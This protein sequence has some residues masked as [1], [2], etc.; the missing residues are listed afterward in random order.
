[1]AKK[2]TKERD[3]VGDYNVACRAIWDKFLIKQ[4]Y[5]ESDGKVFDYE[6]MHSNGVYSY[7]VVGDDY[8][9]IEDAI[10]DLE[11]DTTVGVFFDWYYYTLEW[12]L[13]GYSDVSYQSY[14]NGFRHTERGFFGN[15]WH[16]LKR[17]YN[18]IKW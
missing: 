7:I 8:L 14:I 12:S 4:G 3:V 6:S 15:A 16:D 10:L 11:L 17:I 2:V 1:M 5:V 9:Y 13:D 18:P